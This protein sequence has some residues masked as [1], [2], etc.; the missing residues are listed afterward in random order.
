M[1]ARGCARPGC[2][3]LLLP[4]RKLENVCSYACQG[5]LKVLEATSG[6]SGLIGAKNTRQNK[7]LQS[8]KR[9]SVGRFS[10]ARI[11]SCTYRLDRPGK[12]GAGCLMEVGRP[13]GARQQWIA[14][15]GNRAS[16]PLALAEAKRAA[17][18]MLR[19][20]KE[21]EPRD[22]IAELNRIAAAEFD[23][24]AVAQERK[25]WPHEL[26]GAEFRPGSMP[27][28]PKLRD[29]IL[30]AELLATTHAEPLSGDGFRLEFYDDGYPK[31]AECLRRRARYGP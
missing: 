22:W 24:V 19:E 25:R 1:D 29:A 28:D 11:N 16:E 7:A 6:P 10:F 31:L 17:V 27:I 15:V 8:L 30:D 4:G 23:R 20:R 14:R 5:Q 3:N 2:G 18:A 21:T 26:V 9:Q 13:G 12:L